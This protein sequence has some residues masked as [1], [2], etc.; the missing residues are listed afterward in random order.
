MNE[1]RSARC[2]RARRGN[3]EFEFT[4][5]RHAYTLISRD[6]YFVIQPSTSDNATESRTWACHTIQNS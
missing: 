4:R 6:A 1:K 2:Q 3:P 5:A